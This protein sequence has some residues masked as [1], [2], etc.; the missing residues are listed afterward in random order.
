MWKSGRGAPLPRAG[1]LR[2]VMLSAGGMVLVS[3]DGLLIR[4]LG[5]TDPWQITF[6]RGLFIGLSLGLFLLLRYGRALA[7][8]WRGVGRRGLVS[9]VLM[10]ASNVGFVGAFT[11]TTVA[12]TLVP[13]AA[14]PLFSALLGRVLLGEG[15]PLRTW[16]AI[17][18]ALAGMG[19]MF[20]GEVGT[21]NLVGNL[22][23]LGTAFTLGL[24][25]VVLR[26]AGDRDMTPAVALGGL[27]AAVVLLPVADPGGVSARDL[28]ILA[29]LG[30]VQLPLALALYISGTRYL[31]AAEVALLSLVEAVLGPVW[32]FLGVGEVPSPAAVAGGAL[33][34]AAIVANA[35]WALRYSGAA[36]AG[37]ASGARAPV[38]GNSS[39][40]P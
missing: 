1:H 37:A 4:L 21:G 18:A 28:G 14:S 36:S 17:A 39:R 38:S 27:L 32:A 19:I 7:G 9:A 23:A 2:G 10:G 12:N 5:T 29:W 24:N 40:S 30:L 33:V 34:L 20:G 22:I 31:P 3:P 16:L 35:A 25:L 11:H 13:I 15:V 8:L 26:G 6:Y